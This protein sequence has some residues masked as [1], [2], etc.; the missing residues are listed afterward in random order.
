MTDLTAATTDLSPSDS[1]WTQPQ[2]RGVV[3][4][5]LYQDGRRVKDIAVEECSGFTGREETVVWLGLYEPNP[6]LLEAVR[7]QFD[8]HELIIEDANRA[9]GVGG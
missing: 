4:C 6:E 2:R 7:R 3:N 9:A 1:T 8:L 5:A